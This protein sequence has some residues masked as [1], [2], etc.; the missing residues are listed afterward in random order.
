MPNGARISASL[1]AALLAAALV[2]AL[3]T[4]TLAGTSPKQTELTILH[5]NDVHGHLF[6]FNYNAL[7]AVENDV[8]GAARR[9]TLIREI[10]NSAEHPVLV[11][12]AG[13][14]FTRGPI[15]DLMGVPDF[16]VMNAIPYDVMT[17]GNNEFKG[18]PGMAGQK[19]MLARIKQAKFPVL[20]ANVIDKAT[21]KTLVP[22]SKVFT[23]GD[24]RVGV[25]GLTAP[26]VAA[27][28]QAEGLQINDPI[29]T[30]KSVVPELLAECDFVVALTHIGY[31]MDLQLASAVPQIDV[32]I[33][34]DSHT[35][36][37]QPTLVPGSRQGSP[38][39][40]AGGTIVCQD[41]EWG[42]CVGRLDLV[43]KP[44]GTSRWLVASYQSKLVPVDSSVAPA[45]DV[46]RILS[47][48]TKPYL[49]EVGTLKSA[50]SV[51][52]APAWVAEV[53]R[54]TAQAQVAV[55]PNYTVENGLPA[56]KVTQLDV[57]KLFPFVN[58][59]VRLDVTGKQ[60]LAFIGQMD[61]SLAGIEQRADGYYVDG[62]PVDDKATYSL[63]VEDY[64]AD[65]SPSLAGA[66]RKPM[67]ITTLEAVSKFIA[68]Q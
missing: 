28:P 42:K 15:A 39:W 18:A 54:K 44:S 1:T 12:D 46:E 26:R 17:I 48:Y 3:A 16:D 6:P 14:V 47:G 24:V 27:Y 40:W 23:I 49:K 45:A 58:R 13:D 52:R 56:G 30:A 61:C 10:K 11:M 64:F 57:R 66:S 36:L 34:G 35:W 31:P 8:G 65:T 21:G 59:V 25:F 5:T 38:D 33:G 55:T 22:A 53:M 51:D 62:R 68:A 4:P 9:A 32:I 43:L 29:E 50:V 2:I 20:S 67:G 63:A 19:N 41:G 37:F 60:L 7:G